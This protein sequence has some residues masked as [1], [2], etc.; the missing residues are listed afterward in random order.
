MISFPEKAYVPV[1]CQAQ[2]SFV[3]KDGEIVGDGPGLGMHCL[4]ADSGSDQTS[5]LDTAPAGN[6]NSCPL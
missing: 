2:S 1:P 5:P 4:G 3:S 6:V